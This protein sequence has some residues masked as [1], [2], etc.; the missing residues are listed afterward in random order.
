MGEHADHSNGRTRARE[1]TR[2]I[3][4]ETL[5]SCASLD[6][7]QMFDPVPVNGMSFRTPCSVHYAR[8]LEDFVNARTAQLGRL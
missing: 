1:L 6:V 2:E 7:F 3:E 8:Q 4:A 5:A